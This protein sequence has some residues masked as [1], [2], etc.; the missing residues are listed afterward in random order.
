MGAVRLSG[1]LLLIAMVAV[2]LLLAGWDLRDAV[3]RRRAW[4]GI[5]NMFALEPPFSASTGF[6]MVL[7]LFG[8]VALIL[9]RSL[10]LASFTW[11]VAWLL[12]SEDLYPG[13][14]EA[15]RWVDRAKPLILLAVC[16]VL[17][18]I[19]FRVVG[20]NS[21]VVGT[22]TIYIVGI[23]LYK[24]ATDKRLSRFPVLQVRMADD[25]FLL[26]VI[27]LVFMSTLYSIRQ[28]MT[29][30][31]VGSAVD[32]IFWDVYEWKIPLLNSRLI[33]LSKEVASS[34]YKALANAAVLEYYAY[35]IWLL[36]RMLRRAETPGI[37]PSLG[38]RVPDGI[39]WFTLNVLG[40]VVVATAIAQAF[41]ALFLFQGSSLVAN[42]II[43][44]VIAMLGA[45]ILVL[46]RRRRASF[47]EKS[48]ITQV[49]TE[50][51]GEVTAS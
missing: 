51:G 49:Q 12:A 42:S 10:Q 27:L 2:P 40:A 34:V 7:L 18:W 5:K 6:S 4:T 8:L 43:N 13:I 30:T 45:L 26:I 11:L 37:L 16:Y 22:L 38:R 47:G 15:D 1:T 17:S 32:N 33:P 41:A 46:A 9:A 23:I 25:M 19:G 36:F 21:S 39:L 35:S 14:S 20:T 31:L 44:L 3:G 24:G 29:A 48:T 50:Q 28:D